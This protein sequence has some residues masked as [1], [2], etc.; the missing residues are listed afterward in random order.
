MKPAIL[1]KSLLFFF[2]LVCMLLSI[3]IL[4]S[5][6]NTNQ[7]PISNESLINNVE[8]GIKTLSRD[9]NNKYK[10]I[11]EDKNLKQELVKY[12]K[13]LMD[14][15]DIVNSDNGKVDTNV[16]DKII[17]IL[18]KISIMADKEIMRNDNEDDNS[19]VDALRNQIRAL[20]N[21]IEELMNRSI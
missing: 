19:R 4:T 6:S 1:L 16:A 13:T 11:F 9:I 12:N 21:A 20:L 7:A 14:Q 3:F 17:S 10:N 2:I 15:T 8:N 5:P 18:N